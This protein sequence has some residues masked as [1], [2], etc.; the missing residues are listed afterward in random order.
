MT[1]ALVH[2]YQNL[3][4]EDLNVRGMM[5][6]STPKAQADAAMG[7]IK[8]Q[9]IY[10]GQWHHCNVLLAHRFYPSSKTCSICGY[11]NAKLKREPFW[12]CPSCSTSLDKI[13]NLHHHLYV[14]GVID[15]HFLCME[16]ARSCRNFTESRIRQSK[17]HAVKGRLL[18][19][20]LLIIPNIQGRKTEEETGEE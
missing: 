12:Q 8:R 6:G 1:S 16:P 4:I 15:G 17:A 7:E 19:W 13:K 9:I 3:V 18:I 11:V 2:K 5:S 10:K 20:K 14:G